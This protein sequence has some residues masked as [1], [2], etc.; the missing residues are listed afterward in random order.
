MLWSYSGEMQWDAVNVTRGCG[1]IAQESAVACST[2][3]NLSIAMRTA[4]QMAVPNAEEMVVCSHVNTPV[5][6]WISS[7]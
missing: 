1:S 3:E 6:G 4:Q 2:W 5:D 7:V